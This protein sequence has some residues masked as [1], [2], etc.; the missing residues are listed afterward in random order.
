MKLKFLATIGFAATLYSCDDATSGIGDFLANTDEINAY[1]MSFKATTNTIKFEDLNPKGVY[2]RTNSAYLGK[3]TDMDFGTFSADFITQINCPENYSFP[4]N[5][6]EIEETTLELY[7]NSFY[8][9]PKAPMRVRVDMLTQPIDDDGTDPSLYYTSYDPTLFYDASAS[10]L[11]EKDY[12]AAPD[13]ATIHSIVINLDEN[14][15]DFGSSEKMTFSQWVFQKYKEDHNNF[16][17]A[18]AFIHNVLPGFYVHNTHGEG[19][20]A[21]IYSIWLRMKAKYLTQSSSGKT[22]SLVTAYIPF[23]ATPEVYMSTRLENSDKLDNLVQE[24]THSY[25][26]TPAGLCTEVK[27]PVKEMYEKL[28][29]DTL[30]SVS[31]TFTKL[32]E[33]SENSNE[34]PYKMGIPKNMLLLRKSEV[35]AFFEE[36]RNYDDRSSFIA[37]FNEDSYSYSFTRLNRLISQIFSDMRT[38]PEPAEGWDEYNKLVLIPVTAE[39]DAQQEYIIGLSHDLEVNSAKLIGGE[40]GEKLDVE[41]IYTRPTIER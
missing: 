21:Y 41:V 8:G 3:F 28:S 37:E 10:P 13:T 33:I 2:S 7:Y 14:K 20:V 15:K 34:S 23:S 6:Q 1:S 40:N 31:I 24:K 35:N 18:H 9:D 22:D 4:D 26:K 19:S 39:Y 36:N 27:L 38:K 17:D 12:T 32:K 25:I 29:N 5:L 16:K 11:A 30:N